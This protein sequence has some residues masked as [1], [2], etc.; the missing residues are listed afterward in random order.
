MVGVFVSPAHVNVCLILF[1]AWRVHI[2]VYIYIWGP[3]HDCEYFY[4]RVSVCGLV[5][6]RHAHI[7]RQDGF[8]TP[9][10]P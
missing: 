1:Y 2:Y 5:D 7:D 8:R 9:R 4:M 10:Q 6:N 3:N